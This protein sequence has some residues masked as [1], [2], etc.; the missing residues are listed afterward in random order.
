M[1]NEL[2]KQLTVSE[3]CAGKRID[4]LDDV[5]WS[6]HGYRPVWELFPVLLCLFVPAENTFV[7]LNPTTL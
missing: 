4:V 5:D 2:D 7:G 3:S 6:E 1:F